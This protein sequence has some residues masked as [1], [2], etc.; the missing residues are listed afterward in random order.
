MIAIYIFEPDLINDSHYDIRHWR[1]VYESLQ[2]LDRHFRK[3]GGRLHILYGN[4]VEILDNILHLDDISAVYSHEESGLRITYDRDKAVSRLLREKGIPWI[5]SLSGGV[6]RGLKNRKTWMK[7]WYDTMKADIDEPDLSKAAWH[8]PQEDLLSSFS[9]PEKYTH[10]WSQDDPNMQKGGPVQGERYLRSFVEERHHSYMGSISSPTKSRRSCS[11]LSPYL[12]WGNLSS[13]EVWQAMAHLP[14]N[15]HTKA[16]RDRLRWRCHFIQKFEMEDRMEFE[17]VN[18]GF[19][20]VQYN[21]DP[22]TLERWK[23]GRTGYPLVDASMRCL[24]ATGY[25]NFRMRAMLVSFLTHHLFMHWKEGTAWLARQF[26]DFEPGIHY[27]QFQM[28]AG[29]TGINTI[30]VYNPIKQ[31]HEKDPEGHFI[32]EW[33]PGM[34]NLPLHLIHDPWKITPM[35]E[36]M[37]GFSLK[38][39]YYAPVVPPE[40]LGQQVRSE[41]WAVKSSLKAKKEG[42]RILKKLTNPGRRN[43]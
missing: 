3:Y 25:V 32:R 36:A 18:R 43:A 29:V 5:E 21:T 7:S 28:Q 22:I 20:Q 15:R 16:F 24:I 38:E 31:S 35:E 42:Q 33:V 11:R 9:L 17:H 14:S 27:P 39:D 2:D 34:A 40:E 37:L 23:Q 12:A 10:A 8:T 26:L 13:R 4:A 19:D 1:F 41:L 30:R 6:I